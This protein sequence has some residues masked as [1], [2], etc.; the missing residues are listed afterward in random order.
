M[1]K[2]KLEFTSKVYRRFVAWRCKRQLL[3]RRIFDYELEL[4]NEK[5]IVKRIQDGQV[6]R[7]EELKTC[8]ARIQEIDMFIKYLK[9]S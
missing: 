1:K 6:G 7:R 2:L 4:L 8:Q 3:K 5:W 9:N